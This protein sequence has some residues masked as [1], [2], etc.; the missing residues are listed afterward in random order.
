[1]FEHHEYMIYKFFLSLVN[2][3]TTNIRFFHIIT[4][5]IK[6]FVIFNF[7]ILSRWCGGFAIACYEMMFLMSFPKS[8]ELKN[9][10]F[11]SFNLTCYILCYLI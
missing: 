10:R 2:V 7:V 6:S 3:E 8:I 1:M 4:F 9:L 11:A 5:G